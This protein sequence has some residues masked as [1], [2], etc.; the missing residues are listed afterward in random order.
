[1]P[2][3]LE[4][5]GGP[6]RYICA[7]MP[8][9][10]SRYHDAQ[11]HLRKAAVASLAAMGVLLLLALVY[12]KE[13]MIFSDAS[14]K[15]FRRINMQDLESPQR[16]YGAYVT[17]AVPLV[18]SKLHIP[19]RIILIAYS[20]SF[21]LLFFG[22]AAMLARWR[23]WALCLILTAY[24]LL[25]VS[26]SFFWTNNEIH[27]SVAWMM[28]GFGYAMKEGD[29]CR[30]VHFAVFLF[31]QAFAIMTHPLVV[32][33]LAFL[34]AF[35]WLNGIAPFR[36]RPAWVCATIIV[37]LIGVKLL[38]SSG[39]DYDGRRMYNLLHLHPRELP[40]VLHGPNVRL[41]LARCLRNYWPGNLLLLAGVIAML[42]QRKF[43]SCALVIIAAAALVLMVCLSFPQGYYLYYLEGEWQSLGIIAMGPAAFYVLPRMSGR[44]AL[45]LISAVWLLRIAAIIRVA[46]IYTHR[47]EYIGSLLTK[48]RE[49]GFTKVIVKAREDW[50]E[51]ILFMEWGL[52]SES[53]TLSALQGDYPRRTVCALWPHQ[54]ERFPKGN[55]EVVWNFDCKPAGVM[56]PYYFPIDTTRPYEVMSIEE[57]MR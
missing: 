24:Y 2:C 1:M 26:Q 38:L 48:M 51:P 21:N 49:K 4:E 55:N 6:G 17:E 34:Y 28:L 25:Y 18:L 8:Y 29:A 11:P 54:P 56:N 45:M 44:T 12:Y 20:L 30:R 14:L 33:P 36:G 5:S 47:V 13:R 52:A 35:F 39:Q 19:L 22:V 42:K 23:Q 41:F 15:L 46:P 9:A 10:S 27:Q 31:L 53:T 37:L 50:P 16:R 3:K 32:V 43:L 40:D 57:L 7:P